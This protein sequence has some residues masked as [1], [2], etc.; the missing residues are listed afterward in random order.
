MT[1]RIVQ[2]A[3]LPVLLFSLNLYFARNL[4]S[5]E[6]SAWM[7]SIEAA[8][9]SISRYLIENWRD[10]SWFPLWYG[11]I[12]FQNTYPPLLHVIVACAAAWLRISPALA[13]HAVTAFFY[14]LGPV[15]LYALAVRL[16]RSRW[17]GFW[18]GLLYSVLSPSAFLIDKVRT[19]LGG[20][21]GLRRFQALVFYGEGPHVTGLALIPVALLCLDLALHKRR[22]VHYVIAA[23]ALASVALSNWIAAFSLAL[24]VAMYLVAR[25]RW[26]LALRTAGISALA[27]ALACSWIPPSTIRAI[28]YNAQ[29]IG[30]DY[31]GLY[32]RLP[33]YGSML[34]AAI[35]LLKVAMKKLRV[36]EQMQFFALFALA[37]S[38]ITLGAEWFGLVL[39]PQP[40]RYHLEMDLALCLLAPCLSRR[41]PVR[42]GKSAAAV[43][44]AVVLLFYFPVT[45]A[46]KLARD[47]VKPIDITGTIEYQTAQWLRARQL[48]N[49]RVLVPGSVSFWLNAFSDTPQLGGGF[50]QGLVNREIRVANYVILSAASTGDRA[51]EIENLWLKA[52]GVGWV[53]VGGPKSREVFKPYARPESFA[54]MY[55]AAWTNGDDVVYQTGLEEIAH[56]LSPAEIVKETPQSG[57]EISEIQ[58][59]VPALRNG[60]AALRWTSRHSADIDADMTAGQVLSVQVA[61]HPGWHA[62]VNGSPRRISADGLGWMVVEPGCSGRCTVR[63]SYDG[64]LEMLLARI[65]S[66]GALAGSAVWI[67]AGLVK[68][69]QG[70]SQ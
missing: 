13:H 37:M 63:I 42:G 66:W 64:G 47:L 9:V 32:L 3:A 62:T 20:F 18:A 30:G 70:G 7:G 59:Y 54:P 67:V 40:A 49:Q 8:Y 35:V 21:L 65:A 57:L 69:K 38:V 53:Q 29:L 61:Y 17:Y 41:I 1:R 22:P 16:T 23:M 43:S 28:Q 27:Y 10:L 45:R 31:R 14:C 19:D 58:R 68:R 34:L 50:E 55:A 25:G 11:G 12:P 56:V 15:A 24:A 39:L 44:I 51:G 4:F 46:R 36:P 33:L 52:Y 5:L 48:A 26:N 6:Y 60:S 2:A